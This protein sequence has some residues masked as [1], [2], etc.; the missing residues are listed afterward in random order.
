MVSSV[1]DLVASSDAADH[2]SEVVVGIGHFHGLSLKLS[3]NMEIP[4]EVY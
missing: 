1:V 3:T 2:G 4:A